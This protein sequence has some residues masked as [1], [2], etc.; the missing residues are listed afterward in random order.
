MNADERSS[1]HLGIT[2][3]AERGQDSLRKPAPVNAHA[4]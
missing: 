4:P 3:S 1:I 2:A